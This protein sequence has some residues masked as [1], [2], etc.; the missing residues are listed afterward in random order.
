MIKD[1]FYQSE[2]TQGHTYMYTTMCNKVLIQSFHLII[3]SFK[4][5]NIGMTIM[6]VLIPHVISWLESKEEDCMGIILWHFSH[7]ENSLHSITSSS[8][9]VEQSSF[10][11]EMQQYSKMLYFSGGINWFKIENYMIVWLNPQ[12]TNSVK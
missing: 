9:M 3:H 12:A 6:L 2:C 5:L 8:F 1:G 11:V 4:N 10:N 7:L